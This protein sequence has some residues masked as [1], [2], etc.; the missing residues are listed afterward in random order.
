MRKPSVP[1]CDTAGTSTKSSK[2]VGTFAFCLLCCSAAKCCHLSWQTMSPLRI[3]AARFGMMYQPRA[4]WSASI[5]R[6]TDWP[7]HLCILDCMCGLCTDEC[8]KGCSGPTLKTLQRFGTFGR[9][10]NGPHPVSSSSGKADR[11]AKQAKSVFM[12]LVYL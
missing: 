12:L 6:S 10:S 7:R 4:S 5:K 2:Y 1:A 3:S 8:S 9:R 11:R